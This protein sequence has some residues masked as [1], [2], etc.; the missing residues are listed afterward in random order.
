MFLGSVFEE[1]LL[2]LMA[3]IETELWPAVLAWITAVAVPVIMAYVL[4]TEKR[5]AV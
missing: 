3:V 4:R 5:P 1:E 2:W